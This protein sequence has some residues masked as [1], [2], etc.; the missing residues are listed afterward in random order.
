MLMHETKSQT[1][2]SVKISA[3][4]LAD[5]AS[6]QVARVPSHDSVLLIISP[7]RAAECDGTLSF[8]SNLPREPLAIVCWIQR[9]VN[10]DTFALFRADSDM[11]VAGYVGG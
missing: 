3:H 1:K 9:C 7:G 5:L 10:S 11:R 4:D 2:Q 6:L 8:G